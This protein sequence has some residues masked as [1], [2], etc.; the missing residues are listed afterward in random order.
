MPGQIYRMFGL[1]DGPVGSRVEMSVP[2]R[3]CLVEEAVRRCRRQES[4]Q[5]CSKHV[6][7]DCDRPFEVARM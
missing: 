6:V 1:V 5:S 4:S 7:F 3:E 2:I